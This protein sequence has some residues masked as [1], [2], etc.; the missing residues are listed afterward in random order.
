MMQAEPVD[1]ASL[2]PALAQDWV[3][4]D[5]RER[6][7]ALP[8]GDPNDNKTLLAFA[9]AVEKAEPRATGPAV[10]TLN[11]GRTIIT[12][13]VEASVLALIGIALLLWIVLRSIRAVMAT[14][15]PL[16]VAAL[17]TFEICALSGFALN[18][19]NII[20]LPVLLGVGVA[21]KIYY[22]MAWQR[23]QTD[24]LQS[25]LTR[26]VFFSAMLTGIAF[27]SL[28]FSSHPGTSSMGEL[29]ALSF[30]CTLASALLFQPALMGDPKKKKSFRQAAGEAA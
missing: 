13:F 20:A 29:L 12:A 30:A 17:M 5:G 27:G 10:D 22:I 14:L 25:T 2:P 19:A 28:W 21:F 8:K 23:G 6:V 15:V 3:T 16:L 11:W 1:R 24:F 9:E 4:Q 26:A 7:D 18:Y